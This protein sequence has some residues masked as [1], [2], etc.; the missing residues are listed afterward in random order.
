VNFGQEYVW[1]CHILGHEE[2]DMMRPMIFQVAPAAPSNFAAIRD[3]SGSVTLTWTDNSA[4]ESGFNLQRD[5]DPLFSAPVTV[6]SNS[7]ASAPV[8]AYGGTLTFADTT[9]PGGLLYYRLQAEDDFLPQSQLAPPFQVVPMFSPWVTTTAGVMTITTIQAPAI[10]YGQNGVVT[11]SVTSASGT[12][13]GN[14]TLSVDGGTPISQAL[15]GGVAIY[16]LPLPAV[17]SH[18]LAAS[19]SAQGTFAASSAAGVL[20][21]NQAPL[22]ITARSAS[23]PF[24]SAIPAI[25]PSIV[26]LVNGDTQASLGPLMCSTT[27]TQGSPVGS[28]PTTCSGAVNANYAIT[29]VAGSVTITGVPLTITASS[30]S[31]P[32][33]SAIPAITP[34]VVGFVNGDTIA[35]LGPLVCSTTAALGSPVATYPTTCSGA[36]NANY[37]IAYVP[38]TVTIT[39]VPLAITANNATRLFGLPNPIFTATYVGFVNGNTPASLTGSLACT[40]T[41]TAPSPAG[42]YPITCSGQTS[43]NYSIR[44]VPGV[45]TVT[46][47]VPILTMSPT[48]LAFSSTINVTSAAQLVNVSNT[49]SA[50]LRI[51]GIILGGANPTRFTLTNG[52]PIGGTGL[53]AGASCALTL[54]FTPNNTNNRS[55]LV[56]INVAAPAVSQTVTMTGTTARPTV[57]VSPTAIAFGNQLINTTSPAQQV[58]LANTSAVPLLINSITM[59]GANPARFGQTNNCPIGGTGLAGGG[60]CTINVTFNPTR[61]LARA[62]TLAIRDNATGSPQTVALTGTGQ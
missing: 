34:S 53:A 61:R 9:P 42:N 8:S 56:R 44:Y 57:T 43:T 59:G 18:T 31:V 37:T 13:T 55:A 24:G 28:Y 39:A 19:F 40:T 16:T 12:V 62:A 22:T 21:V 50:P 52:C 14:V 5:T 45:L 2:N 38:G 54:T 27:A 11:V 32:F 20:V 30:A 6:F 46:A 25:T 26:G 7:N 35:S 36:V 17:G 58:T 33:G 29:Y 51:T 10:T 1:H 47:A 23:V 49:G 15:A 41:A 3:V 4:S 60:S 48:A